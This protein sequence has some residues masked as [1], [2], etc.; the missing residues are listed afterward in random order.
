[1]IVERDDRGIARELVRDPL[2][3]DPVEPGEIDDAGG[4][5]VLRQFVGG[6]AGAGFTVMPP[7]VAVSA[8]FEASASESDCVPRLA[9]TT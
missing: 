1:M 5:A 3:V 6:T 7:C 2:V 8:P 9:K 4:D